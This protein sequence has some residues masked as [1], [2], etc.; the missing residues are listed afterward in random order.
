MTPAGLGAGYRSRRHAEVRRSRTFR[1][2]VPTF[3][4]HPGGCF[5]QAFTA[6]IRDSSSRVS[7]PASLHLRRFS[8]P[9]RFTPPRTSRPVSAAHAHGVSL[10]S[11]KTSG[12][13]HVGIPRGVIRRHFPSRCS[14]PLASPVTEVAVRLTRPRQAAG[15]DVAS[16][17]GNR[18]RFRPTAR[19]ISPSRDR[20]PFPA[21]GMLRASTGRGRCRR[22]ASRWLLLS[23][24]LYFRWLLF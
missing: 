14:P 1:T 13:G 11:R 12:G 5:R 6:W 23:T 22:L 21:V 7:R 16:L 2:R 9:W 3:L 18:H 17:D 24:V 8:R 10:P 19:G 4:P 20:R 15:H